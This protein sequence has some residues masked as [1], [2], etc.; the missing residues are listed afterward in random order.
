MK[1]SAKVLADSVA[2]DPWTGEL[3]RLISLEVTFPRYLLAEF[4][5]H[6]Q[7]SRNSASSRAIPVKIRVQQVRE[8]PFVPSAF[9]KNKSGMQADTTIDEAN[10]SVA[11]MIWL[12]AAKSACVAAEGLSN[13]EVHKQQANR[14][15]EAF[16]W[17]TVVVT[18]TYW[19]NFWNLRD[20]EGADPEMI[21]TAKVM[22]AAVEAS[23]PME[24]LPG[25]WH[26]P[27]VNIMDKHTTEG[28]CLFGPSYWDQLVKESV[29]RCAAISYERQNVEKSADDY[30][31][32]HDSLKT[33]GHMSPLEHQAR[34]ATP[35]EIKRYAY[36][37]WDE[38][39]DSFRPVC[40]GNLQVPWFQYRKMIPGEAVFR[41]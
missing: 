32:R 19:D 41:G 5:T 39:T 40:F 18:A 38:K 20:H 6:R 27:Y 29:A 3:V 24:L 26:L 7:F 37:Q 11:E 14:V 23:K 17:H 2:L 25:D 9:T 28:L 15:L 34:V 10:Q 16:V 1:H 4:N 22:R 35:E 21:R 33:G 8:D 30:A 13:I 36:H 12:D 31:K